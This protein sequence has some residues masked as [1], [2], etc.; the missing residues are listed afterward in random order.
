MPI[1]E[2]VCKKC[3]QKTEVIQRIGEAP[4][5]VCPHCGGRLKKAISAPAIQFKGSGWYITDYARA[6]KES[7]TGAKAE[8]DGGEKTGDKADKT[9]KT[10]KAGQAEK[11]SR[12]E[13]SDKPGGKADKKKT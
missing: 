11:V 9:D 10:E 7:G 5:R 6:K 12:S 4:L 3:G 2:Y 1:Y 8:A 13:K